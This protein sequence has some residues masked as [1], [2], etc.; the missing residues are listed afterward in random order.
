MWGA[1]IQARSPD[2]AQRNAGPPFPDCAEFIVGRRFAPTRWL[3]PGYEGGCFASR[4][5]SHTRG[6]VSGKAR[7]SA[8]NGRNA[9]ATAFATAPPTGMMPPSPAPLAPSGLLGEG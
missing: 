5:S 8:P 2:G 4:I 7:G 9:A 6:G 3:H 1:G